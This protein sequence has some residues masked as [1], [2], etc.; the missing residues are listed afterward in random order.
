[1]SVCDKQKMGKRKEERKKDRRKERVLL[2]PLHRHTSASPLVVDFNDRGS[3]RC[4]Y[5][6][7]LPSQDS[8]GDDVESRHKCSGNVV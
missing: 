1:M 7:L 8:A 3:N 6:V 4:H 2:A 5:H